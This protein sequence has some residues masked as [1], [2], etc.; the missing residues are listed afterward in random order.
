MARAAADARRIEIPIATHVKDD[1]IYLKAL[2]A[3]PDMNRFIQL[4]Q[5]PVRVCVCG[6][7]CVCVR[8]CAW[9]VHHS[10]FTDPTPGTMSAAGTGAGIIHSGHRNHRRH[11]HHL[12]RCGYGCSCLCLAG[13]GPN[14]L[15]TASPLPPCSPFTL[16]RVAHGE[17]AKITMTH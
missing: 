16:P 13:Y 6:S 9:L 8:Q 4:C 5:L 17:R 12:H 14:S 3:L 10:S 11:H 2:S 15:S 7:V 1:K